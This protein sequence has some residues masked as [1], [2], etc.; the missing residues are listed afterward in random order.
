MDNDDAFLGRILDRREVLPT[1]LVVPIGSVGL[2]LVPARITL[3]VNA[4]IR[5]VATAEDGREE[6]A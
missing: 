2:K 5:D 6:A 3:M 4:R 1:L